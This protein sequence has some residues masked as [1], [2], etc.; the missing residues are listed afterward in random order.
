MSWPSRRLRGERLE[1]SSTNDEGAPN[2]FRRELPGGDELPDPVLRNAQHLGCGARTDQI[3]LIGV[4]L[5]HDEQPILAV[6]PQ[7]RA[8]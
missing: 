4:A 7:P 6:G 2:P 8:L 1:V 3:A 5:S